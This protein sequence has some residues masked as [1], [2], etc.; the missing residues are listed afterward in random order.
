LLLRIRNTAGKPVA[1]SSIEVWQTNED[2][3]HS[4][5]YKGTQPDMNLR[6]VSTAD[7]EGRFALRLV[8]LRHYPIPDNGVGSHL[9]MRISNSIP[10]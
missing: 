5:Q 1:G 3:F 4:V 2:G 10:I 7:A 6:D 9:G 8:K